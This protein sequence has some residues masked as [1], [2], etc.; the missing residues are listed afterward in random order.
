MPFQPRT[1]AT[2]TLSGT[3]AG[4]A[5]FVRGGGMVAV[6]VRGIGAG[7]V[8]AVQYS[9]DGVT[10]GSM[11][12]TIPAATPEQDFTLGAPGW[13]RVNCT[14]LATGPTFDWTLAVEQ[15]A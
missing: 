14:T 9:P 3:G 13:V 6:S 8:L 2:G 7:D 10:Y 4:S 5:I 12:A 1:R 11:L 15:P